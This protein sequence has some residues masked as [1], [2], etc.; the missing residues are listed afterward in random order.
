MITKAEVE[1]GSLGNKKGWNF[2]VYFNN[3]PYPNF[4]S[5]LFKTKREAEKD[6]KMYKETGDFRLYGSAE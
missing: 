1:K 2:S 3:R 6:L 4:I 5:A